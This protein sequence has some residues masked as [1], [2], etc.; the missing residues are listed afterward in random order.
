[1]QLFRQEPVAFELL[2]RKFTIKQLQTLYEAVY[3]ISF[4][5][6]NFRRKVLPLYIVPTGEIE[7]GVTHRPAQYY[8][9]DNKKYNQINKK[10]FKLN[11][12][13]R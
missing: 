2:P 5:N 7:T 4:D 1:M 9:F 8:Y 3:D 6:R 11:W 10:F 12:N 13:I